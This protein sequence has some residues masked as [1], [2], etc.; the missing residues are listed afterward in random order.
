[1]ASCPRQVD[2]LSYRSINRRLTEQEWL[3]SSPL[4]LVRFTHPTDCGRSDMV[5][6]ISQP[7]RMTKCKSYSWTLA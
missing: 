1:M 4:W 3:L 2:N 5:L 6:I 7:L